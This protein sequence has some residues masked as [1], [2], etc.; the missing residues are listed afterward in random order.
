MIRELIIVFDKKDEEIADTL[1]DLVMAIDDNGYDDIVGTRDNSVHLVK[2][3]KK[4]WE[5]LSTLSKPISNKLIMIDPYEDIA[6]EK[7]S[8]YGVSYGLYEGSLY[9][10][11]DVDGLL[12]N[13]EKTK[14]FFEKYNENVETVTQDPT[15]NTKKKKLGKIF[16][17][18]GTSLLI[19]PGAIFTEKKLNEVED[20]A[21][22][23]KVRKCM[24]IYAIKHL[25]YSYLEEYLSTQD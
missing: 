16:R 13:R 7:F 17:T 18:V 20:K 1:Y 5:E 10:K 11:T 25:Y 21:Q 6:E 8:E 3:D 2:I 24:L 4:S 14:E 23:D 22:R 15:Q 12:S 9:I 19:G